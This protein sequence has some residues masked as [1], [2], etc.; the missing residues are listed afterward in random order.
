MRCLL[1]VMVHERPVDSRMKFVLGLVCVHPGTSQRDTHLFLSQYLVSY[2]GTLPNLQPDIER[3]ILLC[4][5]FNV[6]ITLLEFIMDNFNPD[7]VTESS[8]PL[9]NA[10]RDVM[11]V[12]TVSAESVPHI[13]YFSCH[14][15]VLTRLHIKRGLQH[16]IKFHSF[17]MYHAR[18]AQETYWRQNL[19]PC[20]GHRSS[21]C[22]CY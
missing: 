4:G 22:F 5:D 16:N 19:R 15:P 18:R 9:S 8:T 12:R 2:G 7:G 20:P 14:G 10:C 13:S 17:N 3:P 6:D 1:P 21:H 11:F